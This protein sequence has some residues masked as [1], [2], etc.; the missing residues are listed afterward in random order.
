[1]REIRSSGS[2]RGV[3]SIPYPCRDRLRSEGQKLPCHQGRSSGGS[4]LRIAE[5][6]E[7]NLHLHR[8]LVLFVAAFE[9]FDAVIFEVPDAGCHFIDQ[10]VIVRHQ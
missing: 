5:P 9:V 8:R 3:R 4:A 2:V 1:M 10:V 6:R 7:K